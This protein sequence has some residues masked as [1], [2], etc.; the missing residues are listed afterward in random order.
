[1]YIYYGV[2]VNI[3]LAHIYI[4]LTC[5][6]VDAHHSSRKWAHPFLSSS[7]TSLYGNN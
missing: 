7:V 1:M 2:N 3:Q 4:L 6:F 5:T